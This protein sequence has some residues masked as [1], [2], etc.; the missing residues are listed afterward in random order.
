[1]KRSLEISEEYEKNPGLNI[2]RLKGEVE[3][4]ISKVLLISGLILVV[5]E[6][7]C[8]IVVLLLKQFFQ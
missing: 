5:I 2:G 6:I 8:G 7:V 1:M 3:S 4:K